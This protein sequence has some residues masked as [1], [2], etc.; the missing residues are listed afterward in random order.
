LDF[1]STRG[2]STLAGDAHANTFL[3]VLSC[4]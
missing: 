2:V 3:V 4:T 1:W